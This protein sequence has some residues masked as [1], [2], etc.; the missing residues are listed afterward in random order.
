[1]AALPRGVVLVPILERYA[2]TRAC[3]SLPLYQHIA[4]LITLER[5]GVST[6][7]F[8]KTVSVHTRTTPADRE[9][10]EMADATPT[11]LGAYTL[12]VHRGARRSLPPGAA[13]LAAGS[14]FDLLRVTPPEDAIPG[15]SSSAPPA[16]SAP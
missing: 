3:S 9:A 16:E 15:A 6:D 7:I 1:M 12:W 10:V 4:N 11:D 13:I 2:A 5:S 14:F 8:T